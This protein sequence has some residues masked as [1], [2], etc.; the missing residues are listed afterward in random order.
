MAIGLNDIIRVTAKM[1]W[2][3][4]DVMNV[5]HVYCASVPLASDVDMMTDIAEWLET[6]YGEFDDRLNENLLFEEVLGFNV[7][8]GDPLPTVPWPTLAAGGQTSQMNSIGA[9]MFV[10]MR[11]GV[12]R[13][14]GKKWFAGFTEADM[15]NNYYVGAATAAVAAGMAY[16]MNAFVGTLSSVTFIPAVVDKL[17]GWHDIKE[18]SVDSQPGYQRRR[19]VGSGN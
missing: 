6:I 5:W 19:R 3:G 2:L 4:H 8:D 9:A 14:L 7:S 17:G 12:A 10:I 16:T 18:V 15:E 1:S 11:T 13:V